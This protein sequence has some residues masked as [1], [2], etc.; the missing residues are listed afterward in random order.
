MPDHE[1]RLTGTKV[2]THCFEEKSVF[3][4]QHNKEMK[5]GLDSWCRECKM[6]ASH[7]WRARKRK[8]HFDGW[9]GVD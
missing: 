4:F 2:C 8:P 1:P 3:A 9:P 7:I 6:I 5:D